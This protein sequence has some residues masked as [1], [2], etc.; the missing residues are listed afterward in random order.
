MARKPGKIS[1]STVAAELG[2]SPSAVSRVINNRT[3]VSEETRRQVLALLRQYNF[4]VNYDSGRRRRIAIVS[5]TPVVAPY[6][7][8]VMSGI[9]RYL[10]KH[11]HLS[12][13]MIFYDKTEREPLLSVLRDQQ[14]SGVILLIPS[15][16]ERELGELSLSGL[17]V[18]LVDETTTLPGIGFID[19]DSYLGS[20]QATLHLL[21]LGHR[22][23][24]YLRRGRTLNHLQRFEGY[25][26]TMREANIDILPQWV[27]D[28]QNSPDPATMARQ[29][30]AA[31]PR[32]TAILTTNDE[33]AWHTIRTLRQQRLRVPEDVS[34]VGFDDYPPSACW[35]PPLTTIRHPMEEA[36]EAAIQA[37][38]HYLENNG[39]Q[40]LP[41]EILQTRLVIRESTAPPAV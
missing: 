17:P 30:L 27:V 31:T 39:R 11:D 35:N 29:L 13:N 33:L 36:G 22:R 28:E 7:A 4:K 1:L 41:R 12:G 10:Q 34:V 40:P 14:C 38:D 26:N 16:F 3:G 19:N 15:A 24:G 21:E 25:R 37:I 5:S 18:M 6:I 20:R 23:I 2:I 8:G 9:N 32:V